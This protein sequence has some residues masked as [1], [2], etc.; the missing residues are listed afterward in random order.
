MFDEFKDDMILCGPGFA[1]DIKNHK[2]TILTAT[3]QRVIDMFSTDYLSFDYTDDERGVLMCGALKNVYAI[4]AGL[5]DL[6]EGTPEHT[7]FLNDVA[8]EMKLILEN[9]GAHGETVDLVCGKGDLKITCNYPS[10]N[11]EFGQILKDNPKAEPEK[12]V[13][14]LSALRRIKRG[15]IKVPSDA[16]ILRDLMKRSDEWA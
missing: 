15:E 10:R 13:E 3:D 7:K 12:T 14:G 9:N 2:K 5:L 4:M 8:G 6:K 11:F 1:A 16:I